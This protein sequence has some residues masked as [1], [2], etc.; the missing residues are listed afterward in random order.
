MTITEQQVWLV[1]PTI[2]SLQFSLKKQ[3][4]QQKTYKKL[5][6]VQLPSFLLRPRLL[7]QV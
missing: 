7:T 6:D 2:S 5:K 1:K 4:Q 3:Q